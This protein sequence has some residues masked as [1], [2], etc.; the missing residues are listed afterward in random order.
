MSSEIDV[1]EI[2]PIDVE[3]GILINQWVKIK[4]GHLLIQY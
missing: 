3:N 2:I 1:K 4:Y